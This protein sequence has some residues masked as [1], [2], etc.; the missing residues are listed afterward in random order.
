MLTI[1]TKPKVVAGY[2]RLLLSE[3]TDSLPDEVIGLLWN[4][5][6]HITEGDQSLLNLLNPASNHLLS[7][8]RFSSCVMRIREGSKLIRW[9]RFPELPT[10]YAASKKRPAGVWHANQLAVVLTLNLHAEVIGGTEFL[11]DLQSLAF[12]AA[13]LF[14]LPDIHDKHLVEHAILLHAA[15][16][17]AIGY[18]S[19]DPAHYSFLMSMIHGYLG[20]DEQRLHLLETS[21]RFTDPQD[22]SYLTRAEAYWMEL[23]DL[24]RKHEAEEFLFALRA[25]SSPDHHDEIRDMIETVVQ[26]NGRANGST[27][28]PT[29]KKR[30]VV[31]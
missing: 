25:T 5:M 1:Q 30:R 19:S 31:I 15:A 3:W 7:A 12:Q 16:Q 4:S 17:F 28:T 10:G 8:E 13:I 2:K 26:S 22:H 21:F 24:G 20:D 11:V 27:S 23:L 14:V 6:N 9:A 29:R 18:V